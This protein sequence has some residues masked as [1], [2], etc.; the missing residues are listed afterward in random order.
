MR[1]V[2]TTLGRIELAG[3]FLDDHAALDLDLAGI[4][5]RP[6]HPVG[7]DRQRQLPALPRKREPVVRAVFGGLGVGLP[8]RE[9]HQPVDLTL[10]KSLGPLE[11]HVLDK[12]SQPRLAR[13]LV[14]RADRVIKVAHHDRCTPERQDQGSQSVVEPPFADG[15]VGKPG[16]GG[17]WFQLS[18]H[19]CPSL[20][21]G[22]ASMVPAR[23]GRQ[24]LLSSSRTT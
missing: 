12:V 14:E 20:T 10:G 22:E 13:R 24:R 4:E 3:P 21:S 8:P 16:G 17:A 18:S 7:L 19:G 23:Q 15:Q 9:Q 5:P 1:L 2:E 6:V 11:E